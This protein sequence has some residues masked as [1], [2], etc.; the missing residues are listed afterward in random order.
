MPQWQH[1]PRRSRLLLLLRL[2]LMEPLLPT[3]LQQSRARQVEQQVCLECS[4]SR[5]LSHVFTVHIVLSIQCEHLRLVS[6]CV[7][8]CLFSSFRMRFS[9]VIFLLFSVGDQMLMTVKMHQPELLLA[10]E[11][12]KQIGEDISMDD[13]EVVDLVNVIEEKPVK[14]PTDAPKTLQ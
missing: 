6:F 12:D 2:S 14:G 13:A 9:R 4:L 7:G 5:V 8:F 10:G 3:R 11:E 1:W